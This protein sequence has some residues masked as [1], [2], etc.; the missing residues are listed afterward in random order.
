MIDSS[1]AE[2]WRA[3]QAGDGDA[4]GVLF[5]RYSRRVYNYCFRRTA[6]W[7]AAED[8]TSATF[9]QA[10]VRRD[11]RV[12]TTALPLLLGIA[13]NLTRNHRRS[14]RRLQKALPRL[15]VNDVAPDHAD[16]VGQ[17]LDDAAAMTRTLEAIKALRPIEQDVLALIVWSELSI[18][19][20]AATLGIPVGTV[21]STL[22]RAREKLGRVVEP[23]MTRGHDRGGRFKAA[24]ADRT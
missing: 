7:A 14:L 6:D 9:A 22:S 24:S 16:E 5:D 4:F 21:K 20:T 15:A 23:G 2:L 19:E 12:E 11:L 17:R 3:G 8:L 18:A 13:T 10:W 1:D